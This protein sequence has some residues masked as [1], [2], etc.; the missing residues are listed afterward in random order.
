M[1]Y[2]P[3]LTSHNGSDRFNADRRPPADLL[4]KSMNDLL[5]ERDRLAG[6]GS[7][8]MNAVQDLRSEDLDIAAKAEDDDSAAIAA[9]AGKPIPKPVAVAKLAEDRAEAERAVAAHEAAYSAVT[10]DCSEHVDVVRDATATD[11]AK[12]RVKNLAHVEKLAQ[13]L[14]TAIESAVTANAVQDWLTQG[15]YYKPAQCHITDVIPDAKR[16]GLSPQNQ[17]PYSVREI[18]LGTLT[19]LEN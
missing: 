14:A 2:L 18:I 17:S 1:R 3:N 6:A 7:A 11:A 13:E 19:V 10:Q 8:A 9:R 5:S 15:K 12:A 16:Y 4:P